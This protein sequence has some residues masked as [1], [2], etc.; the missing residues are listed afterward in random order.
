MTR[1]LEFKTAFVAPTDDEIREG[2]EIARA[3]QC[4]VRIVY[5]APYYGYHY[6]DI[7]PHST[8]YECKRAIETPTDYVYHST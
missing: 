8:F 1:I 4:I 2:I 6:L 7:D 3:E 5:F